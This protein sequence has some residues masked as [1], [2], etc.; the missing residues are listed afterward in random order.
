MW[1]E[2]LIVDR[3]G[4]EKM[5]QLVTIQSFKDEF[6]ADAKNAQNTPAE[7]SSVLA[8]YEGATLLSKEIQKKY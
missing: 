1:G 8:M 5:T 3:A 7:P 6:E 4:Y 2:R